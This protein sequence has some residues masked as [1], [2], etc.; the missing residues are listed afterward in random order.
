LR[1]V[2]T[3]EREVF[4]WVKLVSERGLAVAPVKHALVSENGRDVERDRIAAQ[5]WDT[6]ASGQ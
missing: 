4:R 3:S 6:R 2:A 1:A 5:R